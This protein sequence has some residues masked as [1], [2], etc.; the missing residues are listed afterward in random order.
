[1]EKKFILAGFVK[2]TTEVLINL[3]KS[4][5][6]SKGIFFIKK[7]DIE[8][9]RV[10]VFAKN[11]ANYDII[12]AFMGL[13][14]SPLKLDFI[15]EMVKRNIDLSKSFYSP[16]FNIT[17]FE[18]FDDEKIKPL[19]YGLKTG[20]QKEDLRKIAKPLY[21]S[22]QLQIL[23]IG[24]KNKFC[25]QSF[26]HTYA[27]P[28]F[29]AKQMSVILKTFTEGF[30]GNIIADYEIPVYQMKNLYKMF[31][32]E[33]PDSLIRDF[34]TPDCKTETI[35]EINNFFFDYVDKIN[36]QKNKNLKNIILKKFK[37]ENIQKK[38]FDYC[39]IDYKK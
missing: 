37:D 26:F 23:V 17:T 7:E 35:E 18:G 34:A 24:C 1:M 8:K 15:A 39:N 3:D 22:K 25:N 2:D 20:V 28:L 13:E 31:T 29:S 10:D 6:Q 27:N 5:G 30:D 4:R 33:V 38:L 12:L 36:P 9:D 11:T 14:L 16:Q 32:R 19:I 21:N